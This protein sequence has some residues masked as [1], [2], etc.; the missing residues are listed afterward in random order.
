[1]MSAG[2]T[3]LVVTTAV[4]AAVGAVIAAIV[5][6]YVAQVDRLASRVNEL[7]EKRIVELERAGERNRQEHAVIE[8][9]IVQ[10]MSREEQTALVARIE[11]AN[12]EQR[13]TAIQ[14][15]QT[16][17]EM[18]MAA[19]QISELFGKVALLSR[20]VARMQGALDGKA[21]G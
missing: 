13:K 10:R 2:M 11:V 16:A 12:D 7:E 9:A 20:D 3:N 6:R 8:R 19:S 18:R 5:R 14:Q 15:T 17:T 4:Q 1:M 21:G